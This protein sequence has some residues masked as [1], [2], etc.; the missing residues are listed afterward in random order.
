MVEAAV[1]DTAR[2]GGQRPRAAPGGPSA[3]PPTPWPTCA[4][5]EP[6]AELFVILGDDA[7]AGFATWER[8]E[9]VA[10][11]ATL[12]VVDRPGHPD[13]GRRAVRLGARRHPRAGDLQHRAPR[14]GGRRP[15]DPLP[16]A[17]GGRVPASRAV[18]SIVDPMT[19]EQPPSSSRQPRPGV[20]A[21][22]HA[23]S[24]IDGDGRRAA[25][26]RQRESLRGLAGPHP[27]PRP[28]RARRPTIAAAARGRRTRRTERPRRQAAARRRRAP[29]T[30]GRARRAGGDARGRRRRRRPPPR[31]PA[32]APADA[33]RG[34][35]PR[36]G[37]RGRVHRRRPAP[38]GRR[39][40]TSGRAAWRRRRRS[41]A[42]AA[43]DRRAG[44]A[45][46]VAPGRLRR[47]CWSALVAAIPVL[48][49]AGLPA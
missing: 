21:R 44:P 48:G 4:A 14:A 16:D 12:V 31:S 40:R 11:A 27:G 23:R 18:R 30:D 22:R 25:L 20:A 46:D 35:A 28:G 38:A 42:G 32:A 45:A 47:R 8:H 24:G 29:T 41:G 10:G 34:P 39:R 19:P 1:A 33:G 2:P 7:A 5:A 26:R 6:D 43:A 15:I 13:A 17:A 36:G 3:T 9:E 37:A 49:C